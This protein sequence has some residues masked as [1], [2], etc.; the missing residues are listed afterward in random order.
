MNWTELGLGIMSL[1]G[2]ALIFHF[3]TRYKTGIFFGIVCALL[4]SLFTIFNKKL[5]VKHEPS[6]ITLYELSGGF[7]VTTLLLPLYFKWFNLSFEMPLVL[8]WLWL[9]ILAVVCTVIAFILQL[10]ALRKISPFTVNLTYNL[11]PVYGILLA[12]AIFN[13]NKYLTSGFYY[14]LGLIGL[15]V[16][17]QMV[18]NLSESRIAT[19]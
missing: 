2:V 17:L 7:L 10:N 18:R 8:D 4:A 15:A 3:D 11:E 16:M 5:L 13:E 14:G 1:T 12:F 19:D 9:M 6:T